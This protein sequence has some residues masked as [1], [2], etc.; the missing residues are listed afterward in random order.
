MLIFVALLILAALLFGASAFIGTVGAVLGIAA[1]V[2]A[3]MAGAAVFD[4][5]PG[6]FIFGAFLVMA[7]F[8]LWAHFTEPKEKPKSADE[9][10]AMANESIRHA[11]EVRMR[12]ER[13]PE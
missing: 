1:F 11:E 7:G 12:Q 2:A 13:R 6:L 8:G 4:V 10:I 5:D 9:I 3:C